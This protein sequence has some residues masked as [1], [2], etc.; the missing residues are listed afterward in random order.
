MASKNNLPIP[1]QSEPDDQRRRLVAELPT[2]ESTDDSMLEIA[3]K[4]IWALL[5]DQISAT[6]CSQL[7]RLILDQEQVRR[8]Y[9]ECTQLHL[10]LHAVHG[11]EATDPL[12]PPKS[13]VLGTLG[14]NFPVISPSLETGPPLEGP[15][16]EPGGL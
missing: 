12:D 15:L 7:K 16:C 10:D 4:L 6:E 1:P 9:L 11:Q 2:D 14:T 13:P 5:D 3:E 8:R